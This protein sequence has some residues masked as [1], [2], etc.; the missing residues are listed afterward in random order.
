MP[1]L[2]LRM[3]VLLVMVVIAAAIFILNLPKKKG[4][5]KIIKSPEATINIPLPLK[6]FSPLDPE[7]EARR[8]SMEERASGRWGRDPFLLEGARLKNTEGKPTKAPSLNLKL[9]GI[10]WDQNRVHAMIND[11]VVKVGDEIGGA[12]VV[13]IRRDSVTLVK[14]GVQH[15]LRLG[16]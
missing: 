13:A 4:G 2:T 6:A 11:Y 5:P 9:T 14:D 7:V 16:E 8:Q 15:T 1:T 12:K 3:K 10:V